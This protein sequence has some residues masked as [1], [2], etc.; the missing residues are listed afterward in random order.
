[1]RDKRPRPR[2]LLLWGG[3]SWVSLSR[4]FSLFVTSCLFEESKRDPA[5]FFRTLDAPAVGPQCRTATDLLA[6]MEHTQSAEELYLHTLF[7][8]TQH[9][10]QLNTNYWRW[11]HWGQRKGRHCNKS[12]MCGTSPQYLTDRELRTAFHFTPALFA[13]KFASN[14]SLLR[15]RADALTARHSQAA[16]LEIR[17][18]N[19][20]LGGSVPRAPRQSA[21]AHAQALDGNE[22]TAWQI[23]APSFAGTTLSVGLGQRA[24]VCSMSVSVEAASLPPAA[25][26]SLHHRAKKAS[27]WNTT[28][29]TT[30]FSEAKAASPDGSASTRGHEAGF[31]AEGEF[32]TEA[33]A[34]GWVLYRLFIGNRA[35]AKRS[36]GVSGKYFE[37]RLWAGGAPGQASSSG[38]TGSGGR[39]GAVKIFEFQLHGCGGGRQ[40]EPHRDVAVSGDAKAEL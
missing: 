7:M 29:P 23:P 25:S 20:T 10:L 1:V 12:D 13:R 22:F 9:C 28:F 4:D 3:S 19:S 16:R 30:S 36:R 39:R 34:D 32:V 8:S 31:V 38:P 18:A 21:Q 26:F 5:N 17:R 11:V 33:T 27:D 2:G 6:Y 24:R 15:E 14:H 37:L 40:G 35:P